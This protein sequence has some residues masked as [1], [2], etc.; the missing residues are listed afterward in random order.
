MIAGRHAAY[1][2]DQRLGADASA[3]ATLSAAR[4]ALELSRRAGGGVVIS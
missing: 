3:T 2:V 4:G 1:L